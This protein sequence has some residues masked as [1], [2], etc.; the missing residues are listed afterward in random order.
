MSSVDVAYDHQEGIVRCVITGFLSVDDLTVF[1]R[2]LTD[3]VRIARTRGNVVRILFDGSNS[4]VQTAEVVAKM[5][6]VG[7]NIRGPNDFFAIIVASNLMKMQA[8]RNLSDENEEVFLS[9]SAA[10]TWLRS[11][12]SVSET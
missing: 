3:A 4:T 6:E 12:N 7:T 8:K 11:R 1:R 5:K 10:E 2:E 9:A